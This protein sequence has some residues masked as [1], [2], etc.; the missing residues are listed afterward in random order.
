MAASHTPKTGSARRAPVTLSAAA[1]LRAVIAEALRVP[2]DV[3]DEHSAYGRPGRWDSLGHVSILLKCEQ[4]WGVRIDPRVAPDLASFGALLAHLELAAPGGSPLGEHAPRCGHAPVPGHDAPMIQVGLRNV[5]FDETAISRVD[6]AG[7]DLVYRGHSIGALCDAWPLERVVSLL[8]S[9]MGEAPG[10]DWG[11]LVQG[12]R[13]RVREHGLARPS[14]RTLVHDLMAGVPGLIALIDQR[15]DDST[16]LPT[17]YAAMIALMAELG[18]APHEPRPLAS[19]IARAVCAH[20]LDAP[21]LR[22][23][24]VCLIAQAEHGANASAFAA[25]V[26]AG[27]GAGIPE[28]LVAGMASFGGWRHGGAIRDAHDLLGA[29][30]SP[31]EARD[32]IAHLARSGEPV[33]GFGHRVYHLRDPRSAPLLDAL[34]SLGTPRARAM[35]A[36]LTAVLKAGEDL[37]RLGMVP[38]VD[39]FAAA[40]L[41]AI[42]LDREQAYALFVAARVPGWLAHIAEQRAR[43]VLIRP[44]LHYTGPMPA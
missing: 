10:H 2:H 37:I 44:R 34:S 4:A 19:L 24:E 23:A 32:M 25:R 8:L 30:E 16:T 26:A 38:N 18:G 21:S 31:A 14:G 1:R 3:I 22:A 5:Y 11:S 35:H 41:R 13:A 42:G 27:A 15:A 20:D 7:S 28:A 43:R 6:E 9:T 36:T 40:L 12:A 17:Y 39:L 33:P 29:I